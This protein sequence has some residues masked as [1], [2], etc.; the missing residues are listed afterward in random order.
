LTALLDLAADAETR[1]TACTWRFSPASVRRALDAGYTAT[2]LLED[3]NAVSAGNLPQPLEYLI[4]DV[5]RRH[6]TVRASTVACCLRSDDTTLLAEI[7]ADRR[8]RALGLRQLAPT[9]LVADTP[10]PDILAALRK[11]GYAPIAETADGTPVIERVTAYR[12]GTPVQ[13]GAKVLRRK[14]APATA[15]RTVARDPDPAE[16]ARTLIAA[17]DDRPAA[18]SPSLRSVRTA[19]INLT[20]GE[21]RI[22]ADAIDHHR[23]V[24]IDYLNRDG[25]PSSRII[26]NLELT[27]HSLSA[28]CRLREDHRWFNLTRIVGVEPVAEPAG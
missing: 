21:A 22:L 28:W 2:R 11:A 15:R 16:L 6:G 26:D 4:T 9:I 17:P 3:L 19:A 8:L 18:S 10:L 20:V 23:P 1:G 5:G 13:P 25:N 12:T 27:G 14:P 24:A 7:A